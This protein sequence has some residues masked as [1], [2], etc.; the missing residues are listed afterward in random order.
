MHYCLADILQELSGVE[1]AEGGICEESAMCR[2]EGRS[3]H[4]GQ[5][6]YCVNMGTQDLIYRVMCSHQIHSYN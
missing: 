5:T 1:A 2:P 6:F 4:Q 3:F